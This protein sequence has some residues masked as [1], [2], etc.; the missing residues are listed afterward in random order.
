[1][2]AVKAYHILNLGAGVQ[3]TT[4]YLMSLRGDEPELVPRF[5]YAIFADTQEEPESVYKHLAWL[6]SLGGP[7]IIERTVGKLGD[8]LMRGENTTGQRFASIPAFTLA[9]GATEEGRTQRQCTNEYKTALIERTIKREI[10]D[11][12]PKH[13]VPPDRHVLQYFGLSY[14]EAGRIIRVKARHQGIYW[15]TPKF[16]L[17][18]LVM[19]RG[20]CVLYLKDE[21]GI[22]APRSACNCCPNRRN[23]E[24]RWLRDNEPESWE[25]AC[26]I[27]GGLR[28]PGAIVNW[29]M[30]AKLYLHRSCKPLREAPI[31]S[32]E[33]RGEQRLFG[34]D[35]ECEGMCGL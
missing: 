12:E 2:S 17:F 4:L 23:V 19:S 32:P 5:D 27:D 34:F 25:R 15:S 35:Q 14:D 13:R 6:K 21:W 9:D 33:S 22:E 29:G 18:E 11:V 1:M 24:W 7:P 26:Q 16:P 28:R 10:L 30:E 8:D 3:P 20:D 31:D